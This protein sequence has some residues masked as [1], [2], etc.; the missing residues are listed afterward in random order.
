MV[1]SAA[2]TTYV[3][4]P[5]K[6]LAVSPLTCSTPLTLTDTPVVVN[7]ATRSLVSVSLGTVALMWSRLKTPTI[8]GS[9]S[10][11]LK[12]VIPSRSSA[13][14]AAVVASPP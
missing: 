11:K 8:A 6:S 3:T 10:S 2:V 1:A 12:A 9:N 5:V 7:I 14:V 13:V 4:S